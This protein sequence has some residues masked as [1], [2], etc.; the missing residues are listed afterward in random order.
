MTRL[1]H[2]KDGIESDNLKKKQIIVL[3]KRN[4]LEG[5]KHAG[6]DT[7]DGWQQDLFDR[8][9]TGTETRFKRGKICQI[10]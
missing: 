5:G 9:L 7:S 1:P 8:D 3:H 6:I 4:E 2:L 10:L